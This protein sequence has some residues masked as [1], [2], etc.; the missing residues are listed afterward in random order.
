MTGRPMTIFEKDLAVFLP[1]SGIAGSLKIAGPGPEI[2]LLRCL[3]RRTGEEQPF[4]TVVRRINGRRHRQRGA[5]HRAPVDHSQDIAQLIAI[6]NLGSHLIQIA[7]RFKIQI[8]P[9]VIRI[10]EHRVRKRHFA[11]CKHHFV[12]RAFHI[13]GNLFMVQSCEQQLIQESFQGKA[14][15]MDRAFVPKTTFGNALPHLVHDTQRRIEGKAD[16]FLVAGIQADGTHCRVD[17]AGNVVDN[18]LLRVYKTSTGKEQVL[19]NPLHEFFRKV[20]FQHLQTVDGL[21]EENCFIEGLRRDLAIAGRRGSLAVDLELVV[22][23]AV[24]T[25]NTAEVFQIVFPAFQPVQRCRFQR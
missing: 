4:H 2:R 3:F 13:L 19:A 12:D 6:K 11:R 5:R 1:Q 22:M 15:V 8:R 20:A 10:G 17:P 14:V 7:V 24:K 18:F 21:D 16:Q 9:A 25:D 23:V